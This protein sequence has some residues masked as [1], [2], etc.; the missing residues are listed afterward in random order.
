MYLL[1]SL[2][3]RLSTKKDLHGHHVVGAHIL[4]FGH[5]TVDTTAQYLL[6]SVLWE[7]TAENITFFD[8]GNRAKKTFRSHQKLHTWA[9]TQFSE[10]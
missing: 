1:L 10:Y 6:Y 9:I 4:A 3:G 2:S 5:L 7:G 8:W